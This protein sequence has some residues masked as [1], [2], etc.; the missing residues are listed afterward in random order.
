MCDTIVALPSATADGSTILA[1]N[2]DREP[3]EAQALSFFPRRHYLPGTDVRC[4]YITIPQAR[5]THAVL[6]SRPFWMWGAEMGA[7]E[8]GVVIGNEA[9]FAKVKVPRNGLTGMD[10]LRL[11]LERSTTADA[12]L[13]VITSLL[14]TYGQGG[15]GG[16]QHKFYYHNSFIIADRHRAW[17]LETVDRHWAAR[18]VRDVAT[19]SNGLT[20]GNEFDIASH[21][22]VSYAVRRGWCKGRDDFHFA[23]CYSDR[24]YTHFSL[25]RVRQPYTE[26]GLQSRA[27]TLEPEDFMALLRSHGSGAGSASYNSTRGSNGDICMHYGEGLI[28]NSQTTG[29]L[30]AHLRPDGTATFWLT[31]TS[32][33]CLS[34]F[35]PFYLDGSWPDWPEDVAL[36]L[37]PEPSGVYDPDC[38]WWQGEALHRAVLADYPTRAAVFAAD[39]N[40]LERRL[41]AEEA[42]SGRAPGNLASFMA[43]ALAESRAALRAW[44]ARVAATPVRHPAPWW[45]RKRWQALT[46]AAGM[47]G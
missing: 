32:A 9:V 5:E 8:H 39:R 28:R 37:G 46:R 6:L 26:A 40:M 24:L 42:E 15:S 14:E 34:V 12:A 44:H 1:K 11:G 29:S 4:T 43:W 20:I 19:I 18:R 41:I 33:P 3:N 2:S 7:N 30:V 22:L 17:V 47:P 25:C 10:L 35:K 38:L 13:E 16:Y 36:A 45:Y 21:D 23:R 27:G 31:G